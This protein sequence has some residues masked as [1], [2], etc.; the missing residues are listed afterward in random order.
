MEMGQPADRQTFHD[1]LGAGDL[2]KYSRGPVYVALAQDRVCSCR[3]QHRGRILAAIIGIR[4]NSL[5]GPRHRSRL[6]ILS[7]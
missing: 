3:Y 7:G 4:G 2:G 5:L 1:G 6:L